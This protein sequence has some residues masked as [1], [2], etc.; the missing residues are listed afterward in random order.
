MYIVFPLS[1]ARDADLAR[2]KESDGDS[3]VD[4]RTYLLK[5]FWSIRSNV[6]IQCRRPLR[7]PNI[8]TKFGLK[9]GFH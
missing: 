8:E 5:F 2:D 4:V 6:F 1:L 7:L 3:R 9:P